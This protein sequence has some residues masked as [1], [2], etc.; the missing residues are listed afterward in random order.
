MKKVSIYVSNG[1]LEA[2]EDALVA[3]NLCKKH[4]RVINASE[5]ERFKALEGCKNCKIADRKVR[6]KAI[7]VMGKLFRAYDRKPK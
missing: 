1:E 7:N 3:W 4:N 2:L 5:I 6:K